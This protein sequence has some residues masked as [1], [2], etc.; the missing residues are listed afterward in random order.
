MRGSYAEVNNG[1]NRKK[2]C[3]SKNDNG[4]SKEKDKGQL[5]QTKSKNS[6]QPSPDE[7][8]DENKTAVLLRYTR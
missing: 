1:V 7:K 6:N 8:M 2:T 4:L 5:V 3:S